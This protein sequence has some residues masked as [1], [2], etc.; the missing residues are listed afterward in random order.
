MEQEQ[1][2]IIEESNEKTTRKATFAAFLKEWGAFGGAIA[3]FFSLL[4]LFAPIVKYKLADAS[5][6][7]FHLWNYF[8]S[9]LS[10]GW[11]MYVTLGLLILGI[12]LSAFGKWKPSI[13]TGGALSYLVA[14]CFLVLAKDFF[15]SSSTLN[16][17]QI[18][19]ASISWGLG[20][21]LV[22]CV[23]GAAMSMSL[24]YNKSSITIRD[25]AEDGLLIALAFVL[26]FVKIPLGQSGGSANLQM[27]PL[28]FLALRH[29]PAHGLVAGGL[30]YGLLTCLTDGY[31][32]ATFPFDYLVGFGSI[33][34]VGFFKPL[35]LSENQKTYNLKGEIFIFVACVLATFV[36]LMGSTVSSIVIYGYDFIPAIS[37][38]ALYIPATGGLATIILMATYGPICKLNAFFASKNDR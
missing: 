20:L 6:G 27:L 36:R 9:S 2:E 32:I 17:V 5:A 16:G 8:S 15:Y 21:S 22:F 37:Y 26:N 25:L 34:I 38:N 31:G 33:A 1:K 14:L 12:A 23:L 7:N 29:G 18:E 13:A 35:I 19:K 3:G 4:C 28:F 24:S 11:T 30:A 10:Y